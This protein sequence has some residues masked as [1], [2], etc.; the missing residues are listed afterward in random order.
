MFI[1][2]AIIVENGSH[3]FVGE[4]NCHLIPSSSQGHTMVG[5]PYLPLLTKPRDGGGIL[6]SLPHRAIQL[7]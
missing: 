6:P 4:K 5:M 2:F 7:L 3:N 1:F